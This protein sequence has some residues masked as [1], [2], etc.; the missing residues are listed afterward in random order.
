[1]TYNPLNTIDFYKADHRRQYP[2]GTQFV[3]SNFT[4][5]SSRLAMV[6]EGFDNRVVFVGLQ[7]FI[8]NYLI[9]AWDKGFFS[10]PKE[11]VVAQYKKRMDKSLGVDAI[12]LDHIEDLHDLGYL[13]LK[14]KALPEGSRVNI[15]VPMFTIINTIPEFFWL[16]ITR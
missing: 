15:K 1:M 5:R 2:Q 10:Q 8:K 9:K 6:A 13:P 11:S 3:Y 7:G 14:I 4:P 16:T 12:P